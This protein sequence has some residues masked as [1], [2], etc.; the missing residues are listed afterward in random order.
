MPYLTNPFGRIVGVNDQNQYENLLKIKGYKAL[1]SQQEQMHI[2]ERIKTVESMKQTHDAT[3]GVYLS[4]VSQGGKDGYGVSST[5]LIKELRKLGISID[6][7]Y[8]GQKVAILFHNPYGIANIEAPY[9]IIYTMFESTKIPADWGEYLKVADL[10]IVPSKWCQQVFAEAGIKTMVV[11][12]GYDSNIFKFMF[13]ENKR[14][15]KKPFVF[16]HYNAFN[17]RKGFMELFR[18]FTKAFDKT[19][20][21]KLILKTTLEH[22][23][24]PITGAEYPNI[25]IILGK[26]NEADL[27]KIIQQSDCFV[28]PS[29][30]EGFGLTPLEAMATGM[31]AIVPNAHGITEYFDANYMYEVKIKE[32]CPALYSRYKNQ[33]VGQMVVCDIDDLAQKM[34]YIYEHQEEAMAL[35]EKASE[36]VKAWT[37]EKTAHILRDIVNGAIQKFRTHGWS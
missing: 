22:I 15:E 2:L 18:A 21:V 32:T 23:P 14:K 37:F 17:A 24:L 25:E 6:N 12:L 9:R 11:P 7:Y 19:E 13:R 16:L 34:R 27:L 33:D 10:V 31:P 20:P 30:G 26:S 4:T 1:T 5:L 29:R 3:N 35:G 28:F 8:K 36:Y